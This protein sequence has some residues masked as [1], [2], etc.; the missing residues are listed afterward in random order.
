MAPRESGRVWESRE[1]LEIDGLHNELV[2]ADDVSLL[3]E[4]INTTINNAEILYYSKDIDIE[5]NIDKTKYEND[6]KPKSA[7]NRNTTTG[8]TFVSK[9]QHPGTTL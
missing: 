5:V 9:W 3:G 1:G 7:I 2:Y 6:M 4:N 8:N